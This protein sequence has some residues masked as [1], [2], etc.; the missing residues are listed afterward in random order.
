VTGFAVA[1]AIKLG[2]LALAWLEA[3]WPGE[4]GSVPSTCPTCGCRRPKDGRC[5][6]CRWLP[7]DNEKQKEKCLDG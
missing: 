4:H 1:V 6:H 7:E 2:G 3:Y 5:R